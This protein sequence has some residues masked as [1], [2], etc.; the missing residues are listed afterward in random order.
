MASQAVAAV[1]VQA[2]VDRSRPIYAGSRF[3]YSL[4]VSGG[5]IGVGS[6]SPEYAQLVI[7]WKDKRKH[8]SVELMEDI[9]PFLASLSG[10]TIT[11]Q[12]IV[13]EVGGGG[14]P[15]EYYITA[16]DHEMLSGSVGKIL[17]T[18]QNTPGI[19][20][21]D[22]TYHPGKPEINFEI[23]RSRLANLDLDPNSVALNVRAALEGLIPTTFRECD[24]EYDIRVTIP[25]RLK[26]QREVL[27][28]LPVANRMKDV[29]VLKQ[30]VN[31][32][33]SSGP[34]IRE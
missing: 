20:D 11:V 18:L 6:Q 7:N 9:K 19:T 29:F 14:A 15:I 13:S 30:L 23:K 33:E 8:S 24:N 16:P 34:T 12:A 1:G 17:E 21:A 31:I 27:E 28:N 5:E 22:S 3:G 4:V 2:Q 32:E 26:E 25:E 10:A